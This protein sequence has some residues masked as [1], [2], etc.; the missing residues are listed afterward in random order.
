L[1]GTLPPNARSIYTWDLAFEP[2]EQGSLVV[3][4]SYGAGNI[5][6]F[7]W[8]W[9]FAV[10]VYDQDFGWLDLLE[11]ATHLKE[12]PPQTPQPRL[13]LYQYSSDPTTRTLI[14]T[15]FPFEIYTVLASTNLSDWNVLGSVRHFSGQPNLG[16]F[17]FRLG[18]ETNYL[19]RFYKIRREAR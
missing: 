8:N 11:K 13:T 12:P 14:F 16:S 6:F 18:D 10:P 5:I 3:L 4:I 19:Q 9:W 1:D 15:N 17:S 7:G 2:S